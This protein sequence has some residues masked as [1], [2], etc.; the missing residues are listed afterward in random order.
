M[1][2]VKSPFEWVLNDLYKT[3]QHS[4]LFRLFL[5]MIRNMCHVSYEY[6]GMKYG[7]V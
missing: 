2:F 3:F 7:F 4:D 1:T 5:V 6:Q